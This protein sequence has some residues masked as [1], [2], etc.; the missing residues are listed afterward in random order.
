MKLDDFEQE[1][2]N[3]ISEYESASDKKKAIINNIKYGDSFSACHR[4]VNQL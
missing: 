3:N 2:E 4:T 1:S